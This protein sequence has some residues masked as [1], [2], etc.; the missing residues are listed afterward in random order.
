MAAERQHLCNVLEQFW[1]DAVAERLKLSAQS[2]VPLLEQIL[3]DP[4]AA[5]RSL[6][7]L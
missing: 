6:P 1:G 5:T 4:S 3:A 2:A 7:L